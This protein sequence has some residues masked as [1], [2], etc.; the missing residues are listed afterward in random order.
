MP[1]DVVTNARPTNA[2]M[3]TEKPT[4]G[5]GPRNHAYAAAATRLSAK[6]TPNT[7]AGCPVG[8]SGSTPAALHQAFLNSGPYHRPPSRKL[9]NAASRIAHGFRSDM[10]GSPDEG[11]S[12]AKRTVGGERRLHAA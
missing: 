10:R 12:I 2:P 8:L 11:R 9:D 7:R 3:A 1:N 6:A 4:A 5:L